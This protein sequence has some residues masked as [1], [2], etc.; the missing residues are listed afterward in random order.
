[1]TS[2]RDRM[3]AAAADAAVA[4]VEDGMIV[5]LGTG[6]TTWLA[7]AMLARRVA[8]GLRVVGIPTSEQTEREARR[9]GISLST[10]VSR[11]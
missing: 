11:P 7:L 8:K 1:M 4:M 10:L 5:G 6:S 3:K 9:L 2:E